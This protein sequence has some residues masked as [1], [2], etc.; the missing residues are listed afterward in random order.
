MYTLVLVMAF[1]AS[2]LVTFNIEG[3]PSKKDCEEAKAKVAKEY[4]S[5]VVS[6]KCSSSK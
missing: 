4:G 3:I 6:A 2:T 1:K 5:Q